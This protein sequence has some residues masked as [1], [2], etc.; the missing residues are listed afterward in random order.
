MLVKEDDE[1]SEQAMQGDRQNDG[2]MDCALYKTKDQWP[3]STRI[4]VDVESAQLGD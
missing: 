4:S 2:S 1:S 3:S